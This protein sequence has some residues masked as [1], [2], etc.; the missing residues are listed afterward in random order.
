MWTTVMFG[1]KRRKAVSAACRDRQ[2]SEERLRRALRL[3]SE[4]ERIQAENH[5]AENVVKGLLGR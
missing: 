1:R 4:I 5:F 2:L 3:K